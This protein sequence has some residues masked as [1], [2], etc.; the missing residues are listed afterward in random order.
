METKKDRVDT[1]RLQNISYG[2]KAAAV[3]MAAVE[4]DL[5]TKVSEGASTISEIGK[6]L[7]LSPLNAHR[8]VVACTGVGLLEKEGAHYRNPPDVERF[9]VK[10]KRSY[11]GP[12]ILLQKQDFASWAGLGDL[13]RS[14]Q[15]TSVLGAYGSYTYEMAKQLHDATYSVGLCAGMRFARDVDMSNR[16]MILDLGG[17]SGAYCIAAVQKYPHL[18]AI[19]FDL[20]PVCRLAKEFIA[21]WGLTDRIFT[22]PGDFTRDPF[23]SGAD[24]ML[25][26]SNLP[27]YDEERLIQIFKK[28]FEALESGGEY[29]LVGEALDDTTG[30]P[31]GPSLWGLAEV[32][33]HSEGRSHTEGEVKGYLE[34][35]GFV[36]VRIHPFIPGAL[37]RITGRKPQ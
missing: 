1:I 37:S 22:Q 27:Q 26:A 12:W 30:G 9:L 34:A 23:P 32:F 2:H 10:G 15:P 19:V 28:G 11:V 13:L 16:S 4:L 8:L 3:L 29:H 24:V 36:D 5:F 31:L 20:E 25:Q 6:A 35:A 7:N 21:Q 33:Y 17:G 18:K 14:S